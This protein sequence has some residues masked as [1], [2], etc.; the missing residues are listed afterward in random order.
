MHLADLPHVDTDDIKAIREAVRALCTR[1]PG[2]YWRDLDRDKAYP[3]EFVRAMTE[4]G[5][6]S[7]LVPTEYGGTGGSATCG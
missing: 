6:L 1:F 2:E 4:G 3:A 5:F 7:V